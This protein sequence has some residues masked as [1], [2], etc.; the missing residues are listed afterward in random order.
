MAVEFDWSNDQ[1]LTIEGSEKVDWAGLPIDLDLAFSSNQRDRVY[2]QHVM[3]KR[4]AQTWR[5][6]AEDNP[7]LRESAH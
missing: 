2:V 5:W 3:R 7:N 6:P 1:A 4:G